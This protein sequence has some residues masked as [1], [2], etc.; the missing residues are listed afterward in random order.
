MIDSDK[1]AQAYIGV[2]G[3]CTR[4]VESIF[5]YLNQVKCK[6]PDF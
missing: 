5:L 2:C 6:Q 4:V 3:S 1:T